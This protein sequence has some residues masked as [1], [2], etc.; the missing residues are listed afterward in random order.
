MDL[1]SGHCKYL[2]SIQS[3]YTPQNAQIPME[4]TACCM[5]KQTVLELKMLLCFASTPMLPFRVHW[6]FSWSVSVRGKRQQLAKYTDMLSA[7]DGSM[8]TFPEFLANIIK[9][10]HYR[11]FFGQGF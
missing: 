7:F 5:P 6:L 4:K 3:S 10:G 8:T 1:Y 2:V 9:P 11:F